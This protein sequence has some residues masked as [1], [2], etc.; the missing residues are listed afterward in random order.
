MAVTILLRQYAAAIYSTFVDLYEPDLRAWESVGSDDNGRKRAG[1]V[2]HEGESEL[3]HD[4]FPNDASIGAGTPSAQLICRA[5][6]GRGA[7]W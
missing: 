6:R 4:E 1:D 2:G 7:V 5:G 3:D